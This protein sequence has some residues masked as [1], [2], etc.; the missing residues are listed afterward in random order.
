MDMLI[1]L[2]KVEDL[3]LDTPVDWLVQEPSEMTSHWTPNEYG[4]NE[5]LV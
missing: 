1:T 2:E 3:L 5:E 4:V